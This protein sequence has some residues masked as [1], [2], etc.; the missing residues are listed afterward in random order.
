[1]T[2]I[3]KILFGTTLI[4]G[5][6]LSGAGCKSRD[7]NSDDE[8][9]DKIELASIKAKAKFEKKYKIESRAD[10]D[11]LYNDAKPFIFASMISTE[12]WRT[13]FHNDKQK[14]NAV[15]NSVGVGL[16][17]LGVNKNGKLDFNVK[18]DWKKTREYVVTYRKSHN[19]ANPPA[20]KPDQLYAGTQCWFKNM[21]NGRH[22]RELYQH[23]QGSELTINEFAAIASV[24]YNDNAIGR[25]LCDSIKTNYD[26]ARKCAHAILN[27]EIKMSGIDQRRVHEA[28]VYL[29][30]D[31]YCLDLFEL[32][33]DGYLGTS[34]GAGKPYF[35][36]LKAKNGLTD[37]N[38]SAVKKAIC[39]YVVK[40]GHPIKYYISKLSEANKS[41]VLMFSSPTE[42]SVQMDNRNQ[43]YESAQAK[44]N[45]QDY[46]G[47]LDLYQQVIAQNGTSADLYNDVAITY[48]HLG[49]YAEC[50][51]AC[52]KVLAMG[53][54]D[55]YRCATYNA[56]LAYW[57]MGK[58]D[59]AIKN[60]QKSIEHT[61]RYNNGECRDVYE[62]KLQEC[63]KARKNA[64][65]KA[66]KAVAETSVKNNMNKV[67][68]LLQQ[69]KFKLLNQNKQYA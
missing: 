1:M 53:A 37:A 18:G 33:V 55:K 15:P 23:L 19:G 47:A 56:G 40:N 20:L 43:L 39:E 63:I 50:I 24:Y 54:Q 59:D 3:K 16:Y 34:I 49:Q 65:Q 45:A 7:K 52:R 51:D 35:N 9:K 44:Y 62:N 38:L 25:K 30:Y 29:N 57:A 11:T 27:T 36:T 10:F 46:K 14:T 58:Y 66:K 13:D 68:N 32:E 31:N 5:L 8:H 4:C 21:E 64:Q 2:D 48:Y 17:Y 41:A 69:N 61:D 12:N 26:D 28:M 67:N 22:L 6:A 42:T 60:F